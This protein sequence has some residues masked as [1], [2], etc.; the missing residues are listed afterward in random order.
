MTAWTLLCSLGLAAGLCLVVTSIPAFR[1]VRLTQRVEP[2]L[3]LVGRPSKLFSDSPTGLSLP[4]AV[5]LLQ[6]VISDLLR[7]VERISGGS[8]S[9]RTRLDRLGNDRSVDRFRLEQLFWALCASGAAVVVLA[10]RTAAGSRPALVPGTALVLCGGL[11]GVLACDRALTVAVNRRTAQM[12]TEFPTIVE[13]LALSVSAGEG[14]TTALERASR[15]GHGA[16]AQELS[17]SLRDIRSGTPTADAL[18]RLADRVE[19]TEVRR[20]VDAVVVALERGT[21]LADVLQ[22]QTADAREV[23]RREL[24]E[25]GGRKEI[26]MMIPVVFLVLPL[27][28]LFALFPGFYGLSLGS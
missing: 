23:G 4:T 19:L 18:T 22:A 12:R 6:P 1:P 16:F 26:G 13:L 3:G 28:V 24:I 11:F 8:S 17:R 15:V 10:L 9:V 21:P 20:F 14:F 5:R 2:Y 7:R 27:S 25:A